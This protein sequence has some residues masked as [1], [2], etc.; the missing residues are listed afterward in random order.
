MNKSVSIIMPCYN[1]EKF[2]RN[3][4]ESVLSQTYSNWELLVSD[5]G[6][7][8]KTIEIIHEYMQQ[9]TRIK[10]IL[11][12][13][14]N[15]GAAATR[16]RALEKAQNDYIAFLDSD[17]LWHPQKLEK[18]LKFMVDKDIVFSFTL[19][20]AIDEEGNA[21]TKNQKG[22]EVVSYKDFL[23]NKGKIGCLTVMYDRHKC[24][25]ILMPNIRKRQDYAMWLKIMKQGFDAYRINESLAV[26][27]VRRGSVS[28]NKLDGARYMWKVYR[29][30]EGLN[31]IQSI[32]YFLRYAIYHITG[33]LWAKI[34][35]R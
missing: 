12:E 11:A 3:S 25:E 33:I 21:L 4:I 28:S 35:L 31:L 34:R 14:N 7:I 32:Y 9:D 8:D 22:K 27:R 24:G 26:Y 18:Q 6:S 29:K 30:V 17:D 13:G 1:S 16:N 15:T 2:I 10:L 19:F 23:G 20:D 5:D